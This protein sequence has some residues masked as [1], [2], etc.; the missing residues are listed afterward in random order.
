MQG[1]GF[2]IFLFEAAQRLH[3]GMLKTDDSLSGALASVNITNKDVPMP[4]AP[5]YT[6]R[7]A[8]GAK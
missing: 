5:Q 7:K 6:Y 8:H 3:L 2:R 4:D 1:L